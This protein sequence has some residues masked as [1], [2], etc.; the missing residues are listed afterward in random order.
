MPTSAATA[1]TANIDVT[2]NG[3][4]L[5]VDAGSSVAELLARLGLATQAVAVEVNLDLVPRANHAATQLHPGDR[6]EI[7][8]LVGGG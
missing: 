2:V 7:V 4:T 5:A 1:A 6:V 8:T 3:E